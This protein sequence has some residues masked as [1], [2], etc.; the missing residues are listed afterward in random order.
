[1]SPTIVSTARARSSTRADGRPSRR[2]S[3]SPTGRPRGQASPPAPPTGRHEAVERRDGD[4][5]RYRRARASSA[6][7][8]AVNGEIATAL[9][10]RRRRPRRGRRALIELDGTPDKSRLGANAILAVS[11]ACARAEAAVAGEPLWR[12]LAGDAEPLL[13]MPMVNIISGGLHAGR[14][15]DFQDFLV[16]PV[17]ADSYREALRTVV[18]VYDATAE[19]LGEHGLSVLKADEGGFGPRARVARSG[20]GTAR[21]RRRARGP[22]H[23]R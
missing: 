16:M 4:P 19:V 23:R 12:H 7:S 6:R 1:M 3:G 2:S 21:R 13:P 10:R 14:Q 18:A 20:A 5:E 8:S 15:L 11:L 9:P 17:G 22:A